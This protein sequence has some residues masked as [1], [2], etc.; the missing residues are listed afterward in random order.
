MA[1]ESRKTK[2]R[3]HWLQMKK[4]ALRRRSSGEYLTLEETAVAIWDP[5]KE[6]HPMTCM[7]VLKIEKRALSKAREAFIKKYGINSISDVIDPK[8]REIGK[9]T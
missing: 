6:D 2:D 1:Y 7:G 8:F 4:E 9:P 5:K 3:E